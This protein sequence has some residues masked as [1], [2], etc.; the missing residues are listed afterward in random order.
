MSDAALKMATDSPQT[1]QSEPYKNLE[2]DFY[3]VYHKEFAVLLRTEVLDLCA[4]CNQLLI[5]QQ[6]Q[7]TEVLLNSGGVYRFMME[8]TRCEDVLDR[9]H[10]DRQ[11][12]WAY[13]RKL[14]ALIK[15]S[16]SIT[17]KL[18]YLSLMAEK[19][20][21]SVEGNFAMATQFVLHHFYN[22][23]LESTQNFLK[24]VKQLGVLEE[25]CQ[26]PLIFNKYFSPDIKPLL[27]LKTSSSFDSVANPEVTSSNMRALKTQE[28]ILYLVSSLLNNCNTIEYINHLINTKSNKRKEV[29]ANELHEETLNAQRELF[30]SIITF[31]DTQCSRRQIIVD[32]EVVD[33][34]NHVKVVYK[35]LTGFSILMRIQERHYQFFVEHHISLILND[36]IIQGI[37][38][39]F[40]I[41]YIDRFRQQVEKI[42]KR[43]IQK[44]S[45]QKKI[46]LPIPR[47][48]GFHVRPST[49][50]A[51]IVMHYGSKV[52]MT[53]NDTTYNAA[54]PLDLF[55]ANEV[56]N[57][58]K[59][60]EIGKII[61]ESKDGQKYT[62]Q[63]RKLPHQDQI[64]MQ[65]YFLE[66]FRSLQKQ[67]KIVVYE[68]LSMDSLEQ[69]SAGEEFL[70]YV[71]R[72]VAYLM[73]TGKIDMV[74][75][76]AISFEGDSRVL[77]DIAI[78]AEN[79]YG[80]DEVGN[81][82]PLPKEL[83]YLRR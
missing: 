51:R 37:I 38:F 15:H 59:R 62:K 9:V 22:M 16:C 24:E 57:V 60:R 79:G 61:A 77:A 52:T 36:E 48:R 56:I 7:S 30:H 67:G 29:I 46:D 10:A 66:L 47:Y 83:S 69:P 55:R 39:D 6:E 81:N 54:I 75:S 28:T 50:V 40:F 76:L 45:E 19:L 43:L 11:H 68:S 53:L 63:L 44:Y 3:R 34:I 18:Q 21:D 70:E 73:A 74:F 14:V 25:G 17:A 82:V 23:L 49:L 80:E 1:G 32:P 71:K 78:L 27:R 64:L 12:E 13:L 41:N 26:L 2:E 33:L 5:K 65:K 58:G 72:E 42:S 35:L 8:C 31:F 20:S 4:M